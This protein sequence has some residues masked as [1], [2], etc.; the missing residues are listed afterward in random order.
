LSMGIEEKK[1]GEAGYDPCV[2]YDYIYRCL[3]HNMNYVT[4]LADLDSTIDETTWGFSGF[5][6]DAGWRLMNKPKSKGG[7]VSCL[8][9]CLLDISFCLRLTYCAKRRSK[10][11]CH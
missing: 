2:K 4:E 1:R 6:G 10:L 7:V 11:N 3:V 5:F 9:K 8:N